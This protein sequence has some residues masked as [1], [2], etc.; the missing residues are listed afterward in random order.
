MKHA[1]TNKCAK[2]MQAG[3]TPNKVKLLIK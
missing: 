3:K 2:M 1:F